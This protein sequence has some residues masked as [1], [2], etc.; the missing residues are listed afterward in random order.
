MVIWWAV[1]ALLMVALLLA[2]W[3]HGRLATR[4]AHLEYWAAGMLV[5]WTERSATSAELDG[6]AR[7]S[8]ADRRVLLAFLIKLMPELGE[9][10]AQR[11]RDALRRSGLLER[12]ITRV[13]HRSP[14]DRAEACRILGRLGQAES[15]PLLVERLRDPHPMV[16]REAIAALADIRAVEAIGAIAEAIE[17]AGDWSNLATVMTLLRMGHGSAA[18]VGVPLAGAGSPEMTKALLQ[19]TGRLGVAADPSAIRALASH[20][21][22][23]VRVEALRA[24]GSLGPDAESVSVCLTGM[25]DPEWPVRALAAWSLGRL[26]DGRAVPRLE[27]AM[28]DGAYWVRHHVAEALTGLGEPGDAALRRALVDANPFVRDMAAQALYMQAV[29]QGE[30]A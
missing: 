8:A 14:M 30:A 27:R 5:G 19:V 17:A 7:L 29:T 15:T 25:D 23:E 18:G 26:G 13:R 28:G 21:D 16:R 3:W 10:T 1:P 11:T 20:P 6:L 4:A 2:N 9:E 22:A 12:V 24:L